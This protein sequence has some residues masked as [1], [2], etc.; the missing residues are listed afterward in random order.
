MC[1]FSILLL[2]LIPEQGLHGLEEE[3]PLVVNPP[4]GV[5]TSSSVRKPDPFIESMASHPPPAMSS[6]AGINIH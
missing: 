4:Q 5:L 1:R 6:R 2:K 3:L